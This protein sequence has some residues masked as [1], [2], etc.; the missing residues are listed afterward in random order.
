MKFCSFH[1]GIHATESYHDIY[2][3]HIYIIWIWLHGLPFDLQFHLYVYAAI[4]GF[5]H[6]ETIYTTIWVWIWEEIMNRELQS[7]GLLFTSF[8]ILGFPLSKSIFHS[9]IGPTWT[10]VAMHMPHTL[11]IP[12]EAGKHCSRHRYSSYLHQVPGPLLGSITT[13]CPLDKGMIEKMLCVFLIE[14]KAFSD[15][16]RWR[17]GVGMSWSL[18]HPIREHPAF[19][20]ENTKRSLNG[21]CVEWATSCAP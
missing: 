7:W 10:N 17:C 14:C 21:T 8:Y 5:F 4:F 15:W 20:W 9:Y 13:Q 6:H 16:M 19:N 3:P 2:E 12:L 1:V 18:P 11:P